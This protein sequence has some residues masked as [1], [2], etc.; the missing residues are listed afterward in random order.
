MNTNISKKKKIFLLVDFLMIILLVFLDQFTK[1]LAVI[2]LEDKPA[3]KI[4]DG[5]L[6]L[7][8]LKNSGAA[9]G[10][11]QNQKVFFIL[12]AVMILCIIAYVLFRMPDDKKYNIMHILLVMI[13]S[14]A[15]GNMIDRVRN[16]Y[17]VDFIYFV[18]INFPIFNVADIYVTVSTF[19]FVILFLFYYK[20]NDFNFLSF[21]QQKKFR[22]K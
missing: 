3:I 14:G 21:N 17:V 8:F 1:Y 9:F 2:H 19:L 20:E 4:I 16:D 11:L 10:L 7:N 6:E 18:I 15:A 5:V 12:V 22:E 13:A